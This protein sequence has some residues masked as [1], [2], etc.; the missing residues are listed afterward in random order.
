MAE[1]TDAELTFLRSV[2]L[3]GRIATVGTDGMPHVTPVGWSLAQDGTTIEVGGR[4]M[5]KSKKFRDVT[6]TGRAALVID[7]VLPPWRPRGVEIRGRAEVVM[8]P[9]PLIRIHPERVRSWGLKET[10]T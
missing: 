5:E 7:E 3:L 4:D 10:S 6:R 8:G 2:R 9:Q 1:F